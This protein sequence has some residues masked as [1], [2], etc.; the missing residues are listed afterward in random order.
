MDNDMSTLKK[1]MTEIWGME[2]PNLLI[3]VTGGAK[4]F[5]LRGKLKD[6]FRR[7]LMKVALSTG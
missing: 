1:L 5:E 3:F 7:G 4:N 2:R 6:A